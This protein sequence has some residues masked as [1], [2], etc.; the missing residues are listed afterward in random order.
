MNAA[1][2]VRVSSKQQS[3]STQ[4][5]AISRATRARGDKVTAWYAEKQS[6]K[7]N[8]RPE[9]ERLR[10]DVRLGKVKRI[11]VFRLD[12][13]TRGGARFLLELFEELDRCGA[14][15]VSLSDGIELK[16]GLARDI[17]LAVVGAI[18]QGELEALGERI[19]AARDRIKAQGGHWGRPRRV[20]AITARKIRQLVK[21][22]H[23]Q[24][25]I[26]AAVKLPRTTV[27]AVLDKKGPY[28]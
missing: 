11:Y 23:T 7:D 6:G 16:R 28:A 25:E 17:L 4:R 1:A 22:G 27:R 26:A 3:Y 13:L 18:A 20:G 19:S 9:L 12:R 15:L 5:D 8:K 14:E 2:Y 10:A 21:E 24:R